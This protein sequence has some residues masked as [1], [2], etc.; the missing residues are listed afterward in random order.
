MIPRLPELV[1]ST[2]LEQVGASA[3]SMLVR[4]N[5]T[6]GWFDPVPLT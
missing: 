2:T 3:R 4:S 5:R 6:V 1:A